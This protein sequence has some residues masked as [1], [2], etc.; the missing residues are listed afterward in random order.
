MLE[1]M[2]KHMKWMLWGII[3]LITVT[4]L[5]FGLRTQTVSGG[6]AASV[7][8][9]VISTDEVNRVYQN[10]YDNY[11]QILKDQM[12]EGFAKMLRSQALHEL[13]RDRL[14]IQEAERIGLQVGD[15]EL[16]AAIMQI[17]AFSRDGRFDRRNYER[18]L[19]GIN[20][21]PA[22]FEANQ[23]EFLLR[24]KLERLVED[25]VAVNDEEVASAY[26]AKN[27]KAKSGDFAKNKEQFKKTYLAEKQRGALDAFVKGLE[28]KSTIIITDKSLNS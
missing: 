27:P 19:Q 28:N 21:T 5:F 1:Q 10:M 15:E 18:A 11:R 16:Q 24:Q 14:L 6:T 25:G 3:V 20:M 23:R 9:Y 8:G 7:D 12:N 22:M 17:P 4:F 13:V 2:H 26:A